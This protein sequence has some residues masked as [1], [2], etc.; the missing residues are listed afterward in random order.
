MK[1]YI[2][3]L[4][5]IGF[6]VCDST[7][8]L[9]A[10]KPENTIEVIKFMYI[11][12]YPIAMYEQP[13][14]EYTEEHAKMRIPSKNPDNFTKRIKSLTKNDGSTF[15]FLN[16]AFIVKSGG[17]SDTIY[18]DIDLATWK[19]VK[20]GKSEYYYDKDSTYVQ[21]LRRRYRFFKSCW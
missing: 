6:F 18:S 8:K 3:V 2:S 17:K 9:N 19:I 20:N 7:K 11:N 1:K 21:D 12:E 5:L 14:W 16:Y 10:S 13:F 15:T 4:V